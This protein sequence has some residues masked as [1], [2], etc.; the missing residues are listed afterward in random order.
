MA[1]KKSSDL[2]HRDKHGDGFRDSLPELDWSLI[3]VFR[4]RQWIVLSKFPGKKL[5]LFR[6][7]LP[8]RT[9]HHKPGRCSRTVV[10]RKRN[11]FV[12][13]PKGKREMEVRSRFG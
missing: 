11:G 12:C 5:M 8:S 6:L 2:N 13:I 4:D 1:V 10:P 3:L 9:A 7:A